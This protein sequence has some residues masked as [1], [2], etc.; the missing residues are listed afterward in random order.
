MPIC[1]G[2]GVASGEPAV[3]FPWA[4]VFFFTRDFSHVEAGLMAFSRMYY[5]DTTS[6]AFAVS[7]VFLW[8]FFTDFFNVTF[9]LA[10]A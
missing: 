8:A 1:I 4:G 3:L 5:A 7:L 9:S 6:L 10:D 2:M